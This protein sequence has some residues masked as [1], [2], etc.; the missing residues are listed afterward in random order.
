[1]DYLG[2]IFYRGGPFMPIIL[3]TG[4]AGLNFVLVALAKTK[5]KSNYSKKTVQPWLI[6]TSIFVILPVLLG[7]LGYWK[8]IS[9]FNEALLMIGKDISEMNPELIAAANYELFLPLK[10][11]ILVF[12]LLGIP[13]LITLFRANKLPQ[14]TQVTEREI[15]PFSPAILIIL[16]FI[17]GGIAS[18]IKLAYIHGQLPKVRPNDPRPAKAF[19]FLFIPFFN[20]YWVFFVYRRLVLRLNEQLNDKHISYQV[21]KGFITAALITA[22]VPFV[23]V[24]FLAILW[25]ICIFMFQT[26]AN[27]L[28]PKAPIIKHEPQEL[29]EKGISHPSKKLI[30]G[31]SL[32]IYFSLLIVFWGLYSYWASQA[33]SLVQDMKEAPPE[34]G[35]SKA[36]EAIPVEIPEKINEVSPTLD[37]NVMEDKTE[38]IPIPDAPIKVGGQMLPPKV[39]KRVNPIYPESA[40]KSRAQGVVV[41]KAIVDI[42]GR[43]KNVEVL[44]SAPTFDQA[45]IDALKKWIYEPGTL[46]G[47]PTES[48]ITVT[49]YFKLE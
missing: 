42:H 8:A 38:T 48:I 24:I 21:P 4:I 27:H 19:W 16:H 30:F 5:S 1:M 39:V 20:I 34:I 40:R 37:E 35:E 15:R 9:N 43:V 6:I 41:L 11:G 22:F 13:F 36:R 49:F 2:K 46:E 45:A 14:S 31:L 25:P 12:T 33:K 47:K 26:A 23:N 44:R 18:H 3:L 7:F 10:F 32:A 29:L 17:S 28:G